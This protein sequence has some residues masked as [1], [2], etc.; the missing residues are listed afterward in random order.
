VWHSNGITHR[1]LK[2][3]NSLVAHIRASPGILK[4]L[5]P[6]SHTRQERRCGGPEA[7]LDKMN[8]N[9]AHDFRS[10]TSSSYLCARP[11]ETLDNFRGSALCHGV[12]SVDNGERVVGGS[13]IVKSLNTKE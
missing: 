13:Q 11:P 6:K 7:D 3:A 9:A 10:G 12:G 1:D 5:S 2:P 4:R 8:I